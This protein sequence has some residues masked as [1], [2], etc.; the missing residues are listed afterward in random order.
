VTS[1]AH[2]NNAEG[3]WSRYAAALATEAVTDQTL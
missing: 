3:D 1:T 2:V